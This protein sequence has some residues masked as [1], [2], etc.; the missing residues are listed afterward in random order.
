MLC[1]LESVDV[2]SGESGE[3]VVEC[4]DG[5][6]R[7]SGKEQRRDCDCDSDECDCLE[8]VRCALSWKVEGCVTV[9]VD[10]R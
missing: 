6:G 8:T 2:E 4:V 1:A 10:V 7:C 3:C 5:E 9:A